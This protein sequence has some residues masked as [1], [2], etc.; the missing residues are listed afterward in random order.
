MMDRSGPRWQDRVLGR[1]VVLVLV[2][3]ASTAFAAGKDGVATES[4]KAPL[5]VPSE[6]TGAAAD[7]ARIARAAA[8]AFVDS[9]VLDGSVPL[10]TKTLLLERLLEQNP[11]VREPWTYRAADQLGRLA[12]ED[13]D[14]TKAIAYLELAVE[15]RG[16][17]ADLL[18]TLGYLYAEENT[19]LDRAEELV[20]K[21]LATTPPDTREE[22]LGFYHDS[23]GWILFRKGKPEAAVPEL[24]LAMKQAPATPEIRSHLVDVYEALDR[25]EDGSRILAEDLVAARGLDPELRARLRR[26]N[27]TTPIG[28]PLPIEVVVDQKVIARDVAELEATEAV[29]GTILR[30]QSQDG[31]PLVATYY[32]AGT[33]AKGKKP[34]RSANEATTPAVILVPMFGGSRADYDS[35]ARKLAQAGIGALALDPRGH[36]ASVT[37]EVWSYTLFRAD[38]SQFVQGAYLDLEAAIQYL[39]GP[40]EET[41]SEPRPA[42]PL[43]V[44]GASLGGMIGALGSAEGEV[45]QALVLLSP[46]PSPAFVEAVAMQPERATLL[47]AAAGDRTATAGAEAMIAELDRTRSEVVVYPGQAHGTALLAE[48]PALTPLLVRWLGAAFKD[49]RGL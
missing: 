24:E 46:G 3:E 25:V 39:R 48:A 12:I 49:A 6:L 41:T 16:E 15:G 18:N 32:P 35:L 43:G 10:D 44:I 26:L 37:S 31:F 45:V 9:L 47:V 38:L 21:A 19:Q 13:G 4:A 1:L 2:L 34:K 11:G 40:E 8:Y 14:R 5:A 27:H 23:L 22:V 20:R 36:G 28:K 42:R 30:L 7:S 17:D 33:G 29:G